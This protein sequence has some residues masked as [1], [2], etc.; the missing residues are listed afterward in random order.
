MYARMTTVVA[1]FALAVLVLP[2]PCVGAAARPAAA[3]KADF[4]VALDGNDA[5]S[6]KLPQPNAA[7]SD[8]PFRTLRRAQD[9]VRQAKAA[10]QAP[11]SFT[12][13]VRGGTYYLSE[14]L[15]I[16]PRDSGTGQGPVVWAAYPGERAIISGG[17]VIGGWRP[18]PGELWHADIPEVRRGEWYFRQLFVNGQ[19]RSRARHPND[20]YLGTAGPLPGIGDPHQQRG[21]PEASMGFTYREGDMKRWSNLEDVNIWLFH[22]WTASLHWIAELDEQNRVV[23]FTNRCNWPVGY[24]ERS[25]QRYFVE[26]FREALDQPG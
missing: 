6:G 5:W 21:K 10:A 16:D 11:K 23:R 13:L 8:G 18:G 1:L 17:R 20:G 2:E 4:Y 19:R 7:R 22:S 12:V 14:P 15:V 25:G 9:A 3:V 26:N 24:W